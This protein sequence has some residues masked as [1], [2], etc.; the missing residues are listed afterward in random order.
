[1]KSDDCSLDG[2]ELGEVRRSARLLLRRAD[3][4]G[5]FPTPVNELVEAAGLVV[6]REAIL[7]HKWID[8]TYKKLSGRVKIAAQKLVGVLDV[9]DR[10]IHLA[11]NVHPSK[12]VFVK[13]H[14]TGH[15]FLPHQRALFEVIADSDQELDHFTQDIFEREANN[16][17]CEVLFQLDRFADDARDCEF[18]IRT[19]LQLS[20]R[21]GAS[22]YAS[23][24]RYVTTSSRA[25]AI[26]VFEEPSTCSAAA[27]TLRLRRYVP[28][29]RF[30]QQMGQLT[31]LDSYPLS[32]PLGRLIPHN[33][34]TRPTRVQ[35]LGAR[36]VAHRCIIEVFDS[37]F[38]LFYLIC[39]ESDLSRPER[40]AIV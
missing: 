10:R 6:E 38:E 24:R 37:T 33:R 7:D 5:R 12:Q 16:F 2:A 4:L 1:V 36:H 29:P 3:A 14:E 13:L 40:D 26:V 21:Y 27:P 23:L 9:P 20:K 17:A 25:C 22:V 18:G 35:L 19:V 39:L 32:H 31:W 34:F 28:S 11:V 8:R 30:I 15:G